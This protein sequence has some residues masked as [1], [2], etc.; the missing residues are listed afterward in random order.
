MNPRFRSWALTMAAACA[1]VACGDRMPTEMTVESAAQP[2]SSARTSEV[3]GLLKRTEPLT[4]SLSATAVI[5][6]RGGRLQIRD[7]GVRVDFPRGAVSTPTRITV[8]ALRGGN[9]AYL[10]E[11]HG[12]TFNTPVTISQSL[13][14]TAAWKTSLA[15][16]LGGS[17][18]ERLLV[19]PTES[20]AHSLEK[21][22]ARLKDS[23][24]RLEFSIEHFS[25]YMVSV[26]EGAVK[27]EVLIDI[28]GR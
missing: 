8:T 28:T 22:P 2:T 21:R 5:G 3:V 17:Y 23:K 6:P 9:V 24:T 1:M 14:G 7:A 18:F 20:Y 27:V 19:D 4:E 13:Q 15:D 25:G 26:G 10:F 16:S 12:I 11:P